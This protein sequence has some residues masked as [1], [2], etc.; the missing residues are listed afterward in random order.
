MMKVLKDEKGYTLVTV[1][2]ISAVV[3]III[4][5]LFSASIGTYK[6]VKVSESGTQD[7][8][9]A[10]MVA[11]E[12]TA[13]IE[14]E[15]DSINN[16]IAS[17][18]VLPSQLLGMLQTKLAAIAEEKKNECSIDYKTLKDG[19]GEDG[20]VMEKITIT[21]PAGD[22]GKVLTKV[23][24]L[25]TVSEVFQYTAVTPSNMYLYG[26]PYIIGDVNVGGNMYVSDYGNYIEG[27]TKYVQTY[28]PA[29]NGTLTVKGNYYEADQRPSSP[30][31][32]S[33]VNQNYNWKAFDVS[34]INKYFSVAPTLKN[35][36]LTVDKIDVAGII[37][38]K[39]LSWPSGVKINSN[40]PYSSDSSGNGYA[41]DLTVGQNSNPTVNGNLYIRDDLTV[42]QNGS[43]T[44]N[45]NLY[46]YDD[47]TVKGSLTVKGNI[48]V[49]GSAD[50]NGTLSV[51]GA[52]KYIY[53]AGSATLSDV[54]AL[55]LNGVMY[56]NGS[57]ASSGDINTNGSIY[58]RGDADVRNFSNSAGTL[59]LLC[60]G[61]I[62]LANNNLY[63]DNPKEID[64]YLYSN[65]DL[66]IY[67]IGSN[68][69]INGGI[70]GDT[71]SLSASRG[72][73]KQV[74]VYLLGFIFVG[75]ELDFQNPQPT[76]P[77]KSRLTVVFKKDL[78][79]NPPKGIP[80][81]DKMTLK[82]I[83]TSYK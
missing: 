72:T 54:S 24:T 59:I 26:A 58:V 14:N 80:T 8:L 9:K 32:S 82:E 42:G 5:S 55:N 45:G 67:G 6:T 51:T 60:G 79:L 74:P 16:T 25:S 53:V 11:D 12:A 66:F 36:N 78:I 63:Q 65:S 22:S 27:N 83:D 81:V 56:V 2:L 47:L 7:R 23:M 52:D 1:L 71:I 15:V 48:Y 75:Y 44:V 61:N 64:A 38:S 28:Y 21:V 4:I 29:I 46:V 17:G 13:L 43:L 57:V 18:N 33:P 39:A 49:G 40:S 41:Y 19:T 73:T 62:E 30:Q 68:L 77:A 10:E 69:K 76:D 31:T 3:A 50:L 34:N 70:Y 37:T 20:I 35:R